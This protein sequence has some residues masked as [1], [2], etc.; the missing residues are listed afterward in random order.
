MTVKAGEQVDVVVKVQRMNDFKGEFDVQVVIP[1]G[2]AGVTP[3]QAKIPATASEVKLTLKTAKN[4]T[5][6]SNPNFAVKATAKVGNVTLNHET[7]FELTVTKATAANGPSA[8]PERTPLV[9][10]E[11]TVATASF[12][13]ALDLRQD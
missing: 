6:A 1:S 9:R 13:L 4:A 12:P 11:A 7:K 5:V 3:V 8:T 2:F 10:N